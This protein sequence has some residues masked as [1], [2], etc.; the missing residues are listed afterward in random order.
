MAGELDIALIFLRDILPW[1]AAFSI[2]A[3]SLNMEYGYMGIPN[4]G[5]VLAVSGGAFIIG[6][7]PGLL[8]YS[9]YDLSKYGEFYGDSNPF[10]ITQVEKI[11]RSDP[12]LSVS[13]LVL[14]L[15]AAM[16]F[17]AFLGLVS[18][19]PALRLREDYLAMTLLAFGEALIVIG[20]N[21]KY[22][23]N[24]SLGIWI[25]SMLGWLSNFGF[26]ANII[27]WIKSILFLS[28]AVIVYVIVRIFL[29]TPLGRVLKAIRDNEV[30]AR[31]LGKD[32]V[33]YRR[34]VMVFAGALAGLGGA[35]FAL[36]TSAVIAIAY[37]RVDHTFLVWVMVIVGGAGNNLGSII[38]A[39]MFVSVTRIIDFYKY[40]LKQF[41]P[42]EPVW[43]TP[44]ALSITLALIL[45]IR[46]NGILEEKPTK[47]LSDEEIREILA[48]LKKA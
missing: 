10:V 22:P 43:L 39:I 12:I 25:P 9:V 44:L 14:S 6:F 26:D 21:S 37:N 4:F 28:L 30:L 2:L 36:N 8:I 5:K 42:F 47:T 45:L 11:L 24:G 27:Q 7:F 16:A 40:N 19:Y 31:S 17:G 23:V 35:L 46:P 20:Y 34:N 1:I 41:L 38:G 32:I 3:I 13:L 15:L 18:S 48:K 29:R 33:K